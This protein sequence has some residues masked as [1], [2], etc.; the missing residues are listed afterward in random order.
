LSFSGPA[1]YEVQLNAFGAQCGAPSGFVSVTETQVFG[2][3]T[4]LVPVIVI[5]GP[6]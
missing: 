1:T 2:P 3:T 4:W 5:I 6:Q